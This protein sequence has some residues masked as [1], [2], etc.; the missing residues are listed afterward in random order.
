MMTM[1]GND[2]PPMKDKGL[3][4]AEVYSPL[5]TLNG[6]CDYDYNCDDGDDYD[7]NDDVIVNAD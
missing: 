2:D 7:I 3:Y 4:S 6:Q 1:D 5:L